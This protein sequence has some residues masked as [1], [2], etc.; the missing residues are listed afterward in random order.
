MGVKKSK[1][2]FV[3]ITL[4]AFMSLQII[5]MDAM[6]ADISLVDEEKGTQ[7][8]YSIIGQYD[9]NY[10]LPNEII[11]Q[12]NTAFIASND[13]LLII[14]VSDANS[15]ELLG[16]YNSLGVVNDVVLNDGFAFLAT[17]NIGIEVINITDLS[18]PFQQ[19][20]CSI[21][22]NLQAIYI[23][24]NLAYLACE[25]VDLIIVNIADLS[26]MYKLGTFDDPVDNP[27]DPFLG[28]NG[29]AQ[30]V[31][32]RDNVAIVADGEDGLNIID[33]LDPNN[34]IL[35]TKSGNS[36][37][38]YDF[39]IVDNFLYATRYEKG[40]S[41]FNISDVTSPN[42]TSTYYYDAHYNYPTD[43]FVVEDIVYIAHKGRNYTIIDDAIGG[44]EMVNITNPFN[45]V[46]IDKIFLYK[47]ILLVSVYNGVAY[48][49]E[50][51]KSIIIVDVENVGYPLLAKYKL[52]AE[53]KGLVVK[54]KHVFVHEFRNGFEIIDVSNPS[55]PVEIAQLESYYYYKRLAI[56]EDYLFAK[57]YNPQMIIN[58]N[59]LSIDIQDV[60][61][62]TIEEKHDDVTVG[63]IQATSSE[64]YTCTNTF[65]AYE[66]E[67]PYNLNL[68]DE[69]SIYGPFVVL[70]DEI[71]MMTISG[72]LTIIDISNSSNLQTQV[73]D[74][75]EIPISQW[76]EIAYDNNIV[77][78]L[79]RD[80]M[81]IDI[82]DRSKPS[83]VYTILNDVVEFQ[84][85]MIYQ[86]YLFGL[87]TTTGHYFDIFIYDITDPSN[88]I[89]VLTIDS[90]DYQDFYFDGNYLYATAG[91]NG[92]Q[93]IKINGLVF[94]T[95]K[96]DINIT[97]T[98]LSF[99]SIFLI[100]ISFIR[101]R[102][103]KKR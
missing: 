44:L 2:F 21:N 20:F 81:L 68:V 79:H 39:Q 96:I 94:Q 15:P 55:N 37:N 18:T 82:S 60:Y 52:G 34:P 99:G 71:I 61:N 42:C 10:G 87:A 58:F 63:Y 70:K 72:N 36:S 80:L 14:D 91:F 98:I 40:F 6:S 97:F 103:S 1:I 86:N 16:F 29:R 59:L 13:G 3:L 49:Y 83:L 69:L 41:I 17:S 11:F 33:V 46:H 38:T 66:I 50:E 51:D 27:F 25:T 84:D 73:L 24:Q 90:N 32:V 67:S 101:I 85:I 47:N 75:Y 95:S 78:F 62:P 53:S 64:F 8:D 57:V 35:I 23:E 100:I 77:A 92:L 74:S 76:R 19:Y 12:D 7:V 28:I 30:D 5:G 56:S 48:L 89:Q 93:V 4:V 26:N 22:E 54:N 45:P 43:L 31:F 102:K 88:P 65:R 9:D